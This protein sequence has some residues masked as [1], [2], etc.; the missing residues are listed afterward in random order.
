MVFGNPNCHPTAQNCSAAACCTYNGMCP[1]DWTVP[2]TCYYPYYWYN[3]RITTEIAIGIG[4]TVFAFVA[5]TIAVGVIQ[6]FYKHKKSYEAL[7]EKRSET[8]SV[9]K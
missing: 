3:D 9:Q 6:W 2:D 4:L 1:E 7:K 8:S 5:I